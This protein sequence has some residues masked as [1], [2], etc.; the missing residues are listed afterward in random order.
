[1][2]NIVMV[3]KMLSF[4]A[5]VSISDKETCDLFSDQIEI[6]LNSLIR[7]VPGQTHEQNGAHRNSQITERRSLIFVNS[8]LIF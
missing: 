3:P 1:M 2:Q 4:P 6:N 8:A 7:F 5:G